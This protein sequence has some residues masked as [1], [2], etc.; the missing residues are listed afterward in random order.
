MPV[1]DSRY[2][3]SEHISNVSFGTSVQLAEEAIHCLELVAELSAKEF[4]FQFKGGNSLLLIL[5]TPQRFSIDVDI[6]AKTNRERIEQCLDSITEEFGVFTRWE[7]RPHKTKPWLPLVSY[8]LYY[9][10]AVGVENAS[11]M[12]DVQLRRSP[13]KT[14]MKKISCG[15]IFD[16]DREAE[17]P[18]AA[19]IIGDKLLTM[20]PYT[21]GIPMGKGKA[22]QRLKHVFD[23]SR[24]L[25][26]RPDLEDIRD[27]FTGCLS[28]E[29]ELQNKVMTAADV[30]LDTLGYCRSVTHHEALPALESVS[31]PVLKEN[32]TGFSDFRD[33]LFSDEYDWHSLQTDMARV[34]LTMTA[35]CNDTVESDQ[36]IEVLDRRITPDCVTDEAVKKLKIS[37]ETRYYWDFIALWRREGI[38][39]RTD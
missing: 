39:R 18:F 15:D 33:H 30:E 1:A 2:F 19:S 6:A 32:C 4:E 35:V 26:T 5:D 13:Y 29:N 12:L 36:F 8:Y 10:S 34:A 25:D 7:H 23:V 16:C 28:H 3:S 21:L 24:L 27:S 14:S 11:I 9:D 37:D 38:Q 17:L 31:D 20:G 22:A